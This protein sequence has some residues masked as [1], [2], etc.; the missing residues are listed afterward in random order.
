MVTARGS[1]STVLSSPCTVSPLSG[2]VRHC[3]IFSRYGQNSHLQRCRD[4]KIPLR[5]GYPL[6]N[7]PRAT[8]ASQLCW[9]YQIKA[10]R[11]SPTE[12]RQLRIATVRSE[13]SERP[14]SALQV[15]HGTSRTAAQTNGR[16]HVICQILAALPKGRSPPISSLSQARAAHHMPSNRRAAVRV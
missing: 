3:R 8:G 12:V 1:S 4:R 6:G 11:T 5:G 15:D 7:M 16:F 10:G 13:R 9:E 14:P 2:A